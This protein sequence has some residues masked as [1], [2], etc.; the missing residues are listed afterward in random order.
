MYQKVYTHIVLDAFLITISIISA[1]LIQ[2]NWNLNH[3]LIQQLTF[4]VPL[5][6]IGR[7]MTN[8]V[9]GIY[10]QIWRYITYPDIIRLTETCITFSIIMVIINLLSHNVGSPIKIPYGIISVEL[11]YSLIL[12]VGVR[13][14][15]RVL[16][17]YQD[18]KKRSSGNQKLKYTILIGAG[19]AGQQVLHETSHK[20]KLGIKVIGF[21]D[22]DERKQGMIINKVPVIGSIKD[23][24]EI[25]K[26]KDIDLVIICIPSASQD[27]IR[28]ISEVCARAKIKTKIVPGLAELINGKVRLEQLR[29]IKI[30]D[31]LKRD[32][33]DLNFETLKY[34]TEKRI[35][36]TGAGGSIGSELCRQIARFNPKELVLLGKGEYSIYLIHEELKELY[37]E[38]KLYPVIADVKN[39]FR[40][41]YIF[42]THKPDVVF[43]AA[44]HKHVPLMELQPS[45]AIM[46]NVIGT[47][48]VA[49]LALDYHCHNFVLVS[50]DKAV[51]PTNVMGSTKRVA[52]LVMQNLAQHSTST[53]F[54]A[55]RFGNVLGSRGSV[56]PRFKKQI[57]AGGPVTI[58]HPDMTR[59]FMTIPEAA[60]LVIQA[61]NLG[62]GGEIFVLDMGNP[63]KIVDLAKDMITL[64][65]K[66][67][68]EDIQIQFVGLRPGEKIYE[69]LLTAE[70]GTNAT[71]YEKIF[72]APISSV[73]SA[74]IDEKVEKLEKAA[75]ANKDDEIRRLLEDELNILKPLEVK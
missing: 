47:K 2:Y 34:I 49:E 12:M 8:N 17:E 41:E 27:K 32:P 45:E 23:I 6:V 7:L 42:K 68:D 38:L 62:N 72:V 58:T 22:D 16:F 48:N 18:I 5:V 74:F 71:S 11:M 55:V 3:P 29:E 73:D 33:I 35:L 21:L 37:P 25:A 61:G 40:L 9:M 60:Q 24:E 15:R 1:Y 63:V 4:M 46:N 56:I 14:G 65:G 13:I 36:I 51:N 53:K 10:K 70:E 75:I 39:R 31:L 50:T 20:P 44:A 69:E 66:I 54:V 28:K 43:H 26:S 19:E 57:A 52:E 30:T 67:P 59:Y 64:S